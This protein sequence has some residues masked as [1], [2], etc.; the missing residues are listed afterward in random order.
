LLFK[1]RYYLTIFAE[2][3]FL[4]TAEIMETE[5]MET[6]SRAAKS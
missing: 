6:D 2:E 1:Y 4:K 5:S 3:I